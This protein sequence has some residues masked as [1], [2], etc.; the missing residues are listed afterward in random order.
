[1]VKKSNKINGEFKDWIKLI[2]LLDY[3]RDRLLLLRDYAKV[4]LNLP[5]FIKL[6]IFWSLLYI[7]VYS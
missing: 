6:V 7:L 4:G 5:I 2:L 3:I 1:M